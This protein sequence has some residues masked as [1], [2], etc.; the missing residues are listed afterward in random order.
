MKYSEFKQEIKNKAI[1][2]CYML[3]GTEVAVI[4]DCISQIQAQTGLPIIYAETAAMVY[5][6]LRG[7][8]FLDEAAIYVVRYNLHFQ[9]EKRMWSF[10]TDEIKDSYVIFVFERLDNRYAFALHFKE[11]TVKL[12][13][14]TDSE[15]ANQIH[16]EIPQLSALNTSILLRMCC[17]S[18]DFA[19]QECK[20]LKLL[21]TDVN[22]DFE[23][24]VADGTIHN[25]ATASIFDFVD[26][27]CRKNFSA[28]LNCLDDLSDFSSMHLLNL[29]YSN[30]RVIML[31]QTSPNGVATEIAGV[32]SGMVWHNRSRTGIYDTNTL[33]QIV[34]FLITLIDKIT[35]GIIND[36]IALDYAMIKIYTLDKE[37]K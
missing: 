27:M 30:F 5:D 7:Q 15:I 10:F 3:V 8:N 2:N 9:N 18:V 11:C 29:L 31:M 4:N 37:V 24:Y 36:R 22:A 17:G 32:D 14:F 6:E 23:K 35:K 13:K 16:S 33:K 12:E 26:Y 21:S 1:R 34:K 25:Y 20:K 19:I 28:A